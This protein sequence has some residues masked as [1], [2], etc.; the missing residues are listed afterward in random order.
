[1]QCL[2]VVTNNW[3]FLESLSVVKQT[4]P[5]VIVHFTIDNSY[6]K[7][8]ERYFKIKKFIEAIDSQVEYI[9]MREVLTHN[10]DFVVSP[11]R[12]KDGSLYRSI[13]ATH[14][15]V[16][17]G[18]YDYFGSEILNQDLLQGCSLYVR[19]PVSCRFNSICNVKL[20]EIDS[21]LILRTKAYYESEVRCL[22]QLP[23]NTPILFTSPLQE[24]FSIDYRDR[25]MN[26]LVNDYMGQTII[27]KRHP[28]DL[29]SYKV[30]GID[31]IDCAVDM[32]GQFVT[33]LFPNS[34]KLFVFPSTVAFTTGD[35]SKQIVYRVSTDNKYYNDF[36]DDVERLHIFD[37]R[38]M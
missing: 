13:K 37:I 26:Q 8:I 30:T 6:T 18:G 20:L 2:L 23:D 16:E 1:M 11:S 32:P 7:D 17:D 14:I 22:E 33:C 21:D 34:C 10:W 5:G 12:V 27:L 31:F 35:I 28:R 24:D 9:P 19:Q 38:E 3:I 36:F 15:F 25:L 29:D 4:L